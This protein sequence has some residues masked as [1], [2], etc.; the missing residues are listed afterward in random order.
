M[1]RPARSGSPR[2]H[3]VRCALTMAGLFTLGACQA[4]ATASDPAPSS[5]PAPSSTAAAVKETPLQ[6]PTVA[7]T[8]SYPADRVATR[9]VISKLDIDL[10][11]MLQTVEYGT[12]PLCDV[13]MYQPELGQ[14]GQGRATYIYAHAREGMFLP[15]LTSSEANNGQ[16][17]IGDVVEVYTSDDYLFRYQIVEVDRHIL[18]MNDAFAAHTE[19]L[20]LQTSE[21]PHGTVPKLQVIAAFES[22]G[23]ADPKDAHPPAH[24]SICH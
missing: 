14:P 19:E 16:G 13:A 11:V 2:A 10:P 7:P 18:D 21:G 15:L 4:P 20:F 5:P 12:F 8:P 22:A 6:G 24:P 17:M 23:A 1:P 9:I 3:I